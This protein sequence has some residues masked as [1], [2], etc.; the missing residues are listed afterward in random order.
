TAPRRSNHAE[1]RGF[2][3]L[4]LGAE[5]KLGEPSG[6]WGSGS[7][8]ATDEGRMSAESTPTDCR[9]GGNAMKRCGGL[10][11]S[12]VLFGSLAGL[13]QAAEPRAAIEAANRE[14]AAAARK[15]DAAAL[16]ALY[17]STALLLPPNEAIVSG[18]AAIQKYW[19]GALDSGMR[20]VSLTTVEVEVKGDTASEV[21]RYE[22][23]DTAG[24][25]VDKGKYI[26]LWKL[27]GGRWKLHRDMWSS[28]QPPPKP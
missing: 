21:G 7:R 10:V 13:A 18:G 20:D 25:S 27:Q 3:P 4:P 16:A 14:L 15:G 5:Q 26:V 2:V 24:Q 19:Q 12:V 6:S 17:T 23:R 11:S 22:M 1:P 9:R 8:D 28:D